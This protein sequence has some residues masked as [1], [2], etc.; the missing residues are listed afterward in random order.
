C[1]AP[2]AS[3]SAPTMARC[4]LIPKSTSTSSRGLRFPRTTRKKSSGATRRAF[5][6]LT[7]R[8]DVF[9]GAAPSAPGRSS[10]HRYIGRSDHGGPFLDFAREHRRHLGRTF[11]RGGN[12]L[13]R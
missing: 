6:I 7:W 1:S 10:L 4:R 12:T 13:L 11:E 8:R 5:S 3:C 2:I 9:D